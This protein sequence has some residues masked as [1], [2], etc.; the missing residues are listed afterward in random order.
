MSDE[1]DKVDEILDELD[2]DA[3]S[4][5]T[6]PESEE[7]KNQTSEDHTEEPERI[8]KLHQAGAITHEELELLRAHHD[9]SEVVED[10]SKSSITGSPEFGRPL[11]TSEGKEMDFSIV[12]VIEDVDTSKLT[13]RE[14]AEYAVWDDVDVEF[15][16]ESQ[17][18]PGRTVVFWQ[19]YNHSNQE[20]QV[21]HGNIDHIGED[22]IAYNRG[23]SPIREDK[24]EPGW[25]T[26]NWVDISADTRI[27]YVSAIDPPSRLESLKVDGYFPDVHTISI[28]EEMRFPKS[29]LPVTV[30]L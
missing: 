15:P 3:P 4:V 25:R 13:T 16:S 5:E 19:V 2:L 23:E 20:R 12:G 7:E 27:K 18:G 29:D 22:Q 9:S 11:T 1:P 8:R 21:R 24:F 14:A 10:E 30:D 17:G 28:T 26:D 6:T